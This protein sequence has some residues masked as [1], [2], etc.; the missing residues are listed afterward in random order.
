MITYAYER[1]S[2]KDQNLERQDTAIRN[3]RPNILEANIFR[4]KVTGKILTEKI[5]KQ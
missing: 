2:S 4:D 3:F 5:I 1:V